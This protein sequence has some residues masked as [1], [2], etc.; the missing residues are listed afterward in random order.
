MPRIIQIHIP[1]DGPPRVESWT[2]QTGS[3]SPQ[4]EQTA[5]P[6]CTPSEPRDTRERTE[7]SDVE[8]E[9]PHTL[10]ITMT[11]E[12]RE[13]LYHALIAQLEMIADRLGETHPANLKGIEDIREYLLYPE[14]LKNTLELM[15]IFGFDEED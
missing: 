15:Y 10:T 4:T 2:Q 5:H 7:A 9:R 6:T 11:P 3:C 14:L 8:S 13:A 12:Q 1:D